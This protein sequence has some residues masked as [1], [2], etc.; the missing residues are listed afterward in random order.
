MPNTNES[1]A[2]LRVLVVEDEALIAEEIQDR[3]TRSGFRVMGVCDTAEQAIKAADEFNPDLVPMDIRL[4][5]K[6]DGID[7]ASRIYQRL[8]IPV[9]YLTAH[10]DQATLQRA[11]ATVPFG[12]LLKPFQERDLLVTIEMAIQRHALEQRLKSSELKYAATLASIADGVIAT[13]TDGKSVV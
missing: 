2:G 4:K 5:G 6:M 8:Q 7:A 3:L 11:K 10:S 12:Y 1:G 9:I 13:D